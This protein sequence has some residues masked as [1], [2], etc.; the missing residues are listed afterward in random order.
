MANLSV[1]NAGGTT[2]YIVA[3]GAGDNSDPHVPG[4]GGNVAHDAVD[5]GNPIKIGGKAKSSD[6]TVVATADRVD[7]LFDLIGRQVVALGAIP[8]NSLSGTTAAMTATTATDIIA[9]QASGVRIY[10]TSIIVA[11]QHA[12]V[13]TAVQILDG[14][15]VVAT[16]YVDAK[17]TEGF[18]F[19]FP[20]RGTAATALRA[21]NV[22]TGS[23]TIV[24]A[25]GYKGV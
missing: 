1:K 16:V 5:A 2:A 12:T 19:P 24:T 7:A 11:N 25:I 9:A 15:T 14:A 23:S 6:P 3:T 13:G 22:T 4:H 21:L 17:K 20:L 8:E 18:A 10:C